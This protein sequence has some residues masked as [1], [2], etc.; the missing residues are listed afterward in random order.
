MPATLDV[1][2]SGDTDLVLTRR[3]NAS[4][5]L[6]WR[7]LTDPQ[8]LPRWQWAEDWP[9]VTCEMD[10]TVGGAFRWV[11]RTAPDRLMGVRGRFLTVEAPR[12]LIHT[13][14]FDADWTGGETTVTQTLTEIAPQTTRLAMT[15]RYSTAAARAAA[16]ASGMLPGM[17]DAYAKLDTLL[18]ALI[19]ELGRSDFRF[20]ATGDRQIT[21]TRSFAAPK[22]AVFR[23]HTEAALLARWMGS[24]DMPLSVCEMDPRPGGQYRYTWVMQ[25][26]TRI[27][28]SGTIQ[29]LTPDR[30]TAVEVFDPDWTGGPATVETIFSET[31]GRTT[32]QVTVT[33]T[34]APARDQVLASGMGEGMAGSYDLLEILI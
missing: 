33:Y 21:V 13:E 30:I 7:A 28:L 14:T 2:L 23:A 12:C 32:V 34:T 4:P 16:V 1:T 8:I 10:V 9:M 27:T 26:G 19:P 31:A 6:L 11:W 20:V 24:A 17:E 25:D 22:P 29:T 18:P 5:A 15:V 3:F